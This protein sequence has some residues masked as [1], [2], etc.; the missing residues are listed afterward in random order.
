MAGQPKGASEVEKK[1]VKLEKLKVEYVKVDDLKPN[2]Y[3]PNRQSDHDF[4]LLLRSMREDGFTQPIVALKETKVIVD[5]E[6]RWRAGQALGYD[7]VPVVFV[8]MTE[9]QAK[10]ATLRHNRARGSEDFELASSVLRDLAELGALDWAQDSLMLDETELER[11]L[12][13]VP[14]P[15]ALAGEEFSQ[16]WQPSATDETGAVD[17]ADTAPR[18]EQ[19]VVTASPGGGQQMEAMSAQAIEAARERERKLALARTAEE[20]EQVA[21]EAAKFFRLMLMF[22]GDEATLVKSVLGDKAAQKLLEL[23]RFWVEAHPEDA[24]AA[25]E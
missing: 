10:I 14:A 17:D 11:M 23:V 18:T 1:A 22:E 6:H 21:R 7:E 3:N 25:A 4:E 13:E 8:D 9:A 20:R 5:G 12:E 15:E 16:A 2:T 24:P 19:S